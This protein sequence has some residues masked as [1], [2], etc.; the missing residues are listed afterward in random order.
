MDDAGGTPASV[1]AEKCRWFSQLRRFSGWELSQNVIPLG[2]ASRVPEKASPYRN[3]QLP[4][5][6]LPVRRAIVRPVGSLA[7]PT[8]PAHPPGFRIVPV[9]TGRTVTRMANYGRSWAFL[10]A[11]RRQGAQCTGFRLA[12]PQSP[13]GA[14]PGASSIR[15]KQAREREA[16]GSIVHPSGRMASRIVPGCSGASGRSAYQLDDSIQHSLCLPIIIIFQTILV[17]CYWRG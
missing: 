14:L 16:F 5:S 6:P 9:R 17:Y 2:C 1:I 12:R 4:G 10:G 11:V 3:G 15:V 13:R 8:V 7:S